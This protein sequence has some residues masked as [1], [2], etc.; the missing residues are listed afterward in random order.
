MSSER[1][2]EVKKSAADSKKANVSLIKI[3]LRNLKDYVDD[4]QFCGSSINPVQIANNL[5]E[6]GLTGVLYYATTDDMKRTGNN[7][8][9]KQGNF[10]AT[11]HS[12]VEE[13]PGYAFVFCQED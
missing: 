8:Q 9:S 7:L 3:R 2:P 5:E 11:K 1:E 12:K 10:P 13:G 6:D 4:G